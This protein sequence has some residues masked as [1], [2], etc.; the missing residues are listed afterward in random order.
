MKSTATS[1]P[2]EKNVGEM[3]TIDPVTLKLDDTLR[4][5]DDLM[6]LTHVRHFPVL[7]GDQVVGI[8]NQEDLL[9]ASM[10]SLLR[11]RKDRLRASLGAVAVKSVMKAAVLVSPDTAISDAARTVVEKDATCLLVTEGNKLLGIV[12]R[13]DLLR[14]LANVERRLS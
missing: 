1:Q 2:A 7:D 3:M 12:T 8:V 11:H 10:A 14:E 4:L 9:H 5:A 6:N 13:T